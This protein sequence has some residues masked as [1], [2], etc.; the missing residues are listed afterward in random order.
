MQD[1]QIGLYD[2]V[3]STPLESNKSLVEEA[4]AAMKGLKGRSLGGRLLTVNAARL[5]AEQRSWAD[6]ERP[7]RPRG[8][9]DRRTAVG[10]GRSTAVPEESTVRGIA[11]LAPLSYRQE[12]PMTG[13]RVC[14]VASSLPAVLAVL[15]TED[16]AATGTEIGGQRRVADGKLWERQPLLIPHTAEVARYEIGMAKHTVLLDGLRG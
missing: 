6:G 5:R 15:F 1:A 12:R 16:K 9:G 14:L 13:A 10:A 7:R 11:V 3:V 8:E 2:L 4:Q